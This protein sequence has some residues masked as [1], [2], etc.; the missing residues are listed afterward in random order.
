MACFVYTMITIA[1]ALTFIVNVWMFG[2]LDVWMF[3]CLDVWHESM[4][5]FTIVNVKF[6]GATP[7]TEALMHYLMC[8]QR[9]RWFEQPVYMYP[10]GQVPHQKEERNRSTVYVPS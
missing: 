6:A 1:S 5:I 4:T 3:G 10:L 9:K 8:L 7:P 2:C